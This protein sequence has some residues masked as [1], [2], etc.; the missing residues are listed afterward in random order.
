MSTSFP[1]KPLPQEVRVSLGLCGCLPIA[2]GILLAAQ[3]A[4]LARPPF[5]AGIGTLFG[6]AIAVAVSFASGVGLIGFA[7]RHRVLSALELESL[8]LAPLPALSVDSIVSRFQ[9]FGP[10]VRRVIVDIDRRRIQFLGCHTPRRFLAVAQAEYVC[11]FDDL[12]DVYRCSHRG[13]SLRIVTRTGTARIPGSATNYMLL[14]ERLPQCL[15]E[16]RAVIDIA[17]PMM[18]LLYVFAALVG[19]FTALALVPRATSALTTASLMAAGAALG[20]TL[21]HLSVAYFNA[22]TG[23]S[24]V[25]ALVRKIWNCTIGIPR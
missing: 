12:I 23:R 5:T 4:Q 18:G 25:P 6:L 20:I 11:S 22:K 8:D 19:L 3:L 17:H 16:T 14:C 15:P 2:F 7:I 24:I 1:R 13:D 10:G 21:I 9:G